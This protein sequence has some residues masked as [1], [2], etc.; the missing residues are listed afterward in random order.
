[1]MRDHRQVVAAQK[2][3]RSASSFFSSAPGA[4]EVDSHAPQ[5]AGTSKMLNYAKF[6]EVGSI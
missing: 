6:S 2:P 4:G 5:K 3:I 1:M